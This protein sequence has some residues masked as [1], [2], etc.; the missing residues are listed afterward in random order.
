MYIKHC[1]KTLLKS[2]SVAEP[3]FP[4]DKDAEHK[5]FLKYCCHGWIT[6]MVWVGV[7]VSLEWS[8][9]VSIGYGKCRYG[10]M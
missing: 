3:T 10:W 6:P 8:H 5:R 1:F 4:P 2:F 9:T 7:C